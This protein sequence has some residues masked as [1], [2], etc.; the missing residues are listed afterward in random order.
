[1]LWVLEVCCVCFV[2]P[3]ETPR[4]DSLAC[5][6][7]PVASAEEREASRAVVGRE[8]FL[9]EEELKQTVWKMWQ[10]GKK[11]KGGPVRRYPHFWHSTGQL[12]PG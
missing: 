1:M 12:S 3:A 9:K 7:A 8:A 10:K 5:C 11:G 2:S 6:V 4:N